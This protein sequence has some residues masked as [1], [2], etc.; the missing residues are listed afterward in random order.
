MRNKQ[1]YNNK[2]IMIKMRKYLFAFMAL[3]GWSSQM[4]AADHLGVPDITVPKGGTNVLEVS[5]ENTERSYGGFQFDM[6]LPAG[7]SAVAIEKTARLTVIDGYTLSINLTDEGNNIYTVLGYNMSHE[8]ISGTT[9]AVA[10]ITLQADGGMT[11]GDV[12]DA[13][14]Q[15]VVLSTVSADNIDAPDAEFA[16]TIG[17]PA[18]PRV[19]LDETSMTMPEAA[20]GVDVRMKRAIKANSWSTICLPFAMTEAQVKAAFGDDVLL[21]DFIGAE[22]TKEG[23]NVV[24][25]TVKFADVTAIEANHPYLINVSSDVSEF[26]V[27]G[28]DIDPVAEPSVDK[29]EKSV[30]IGKNWMTFYNRF[31]G[32]YVAQTEVP[33]LCLFISNDK[34]YYSNGSTKMKA[35]RGYF[36]FYDVLTAVEQGASARINMIDVEP[37]GIANAKVNLNANDSYF[38]LAGQKVQNPKK[39]LYIKNN[40]KVVLK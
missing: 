32:T 4:M 10:K 37:T 39:G 27:D 23:D 30:K 6:K 13:R 7:I 28:V 8:S 36:D 12:S 24:G 26:T 15:D 16:I 17:E 11:V 20:T 35:F 29:D 1:K 33:E 19:I 38:N 18:D 5:L 14:L 2:T 40:K 31:V 34:F 3:F 21:K 9:G 25:I 22:T